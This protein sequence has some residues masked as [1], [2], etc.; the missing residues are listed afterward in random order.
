MIKSVN[1]LI[2]CVD[3][4]TMPACIESFVTAILSF[5]IICWGILLLYKRF[6]VKGTILSQKSIIIINILIANISINII[7]N[8]LKVLLSISFLNKLIRFIIL[9]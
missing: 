1:S 4:I 8:K 5:L 7:N 2:D 3:N 6:Q 9:C